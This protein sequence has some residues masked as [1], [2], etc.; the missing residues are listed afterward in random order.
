M[1]VQLAGKV[2]GVSFRSQAHRFATRLDIKGYIT[3]LPSRDIVIMAEG[4]RE[5]LEAFV[6][7]LKAGPKNA[8]IERFEMEW[9][10]YTGEHDR[11]TISFWEEAGEQS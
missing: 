11:F 6:R 10:P 9:L 1:R 2:L 8:E 4:E 3:S 5:N 7:W